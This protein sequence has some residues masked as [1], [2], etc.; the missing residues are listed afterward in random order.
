MTDGRLPKPLGRW[1]NC[2]HIK[3]DW[4]YD[5][6]EDIVQRVTPGGLLR[7][8]Q[9]SETQVTR[10]QQQYV[11][12]KTQTSADGPS[13]LPC[14][15]FHLDYCAIA[16]VS[17]E[18][19][20]MDSTPQKETLF[21]FLKTWGVE[22][23]W[24]NISNEGPGLSWT[25]KAMMNGNTVWVTD[26]S[27]MKEIS[28]TISGARWILLCTQSGF[29]LCGSFAEST[30]SAGSYRGELLGILAIHTLCA[31]LEA[32]YYLTAAIG[33]ICSNNQG[34]LFKSNQTRRRIPT[35]ASQAGIKRSL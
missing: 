8:V 27:Y 31:A 18:P 6:E 26:G 15:I 4:F 12:A 11:L 21:E 32:Y 35:V 13:G 34:S 5:E 29:R 24:T 1:L 22:W 3:C 28:P 30:S 9:A 33:V 19:E 20:L 7:Y 17:Q 10:E 23:M 16:L 2:L 25:I 14:T